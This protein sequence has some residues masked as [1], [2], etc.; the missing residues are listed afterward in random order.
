MGKT[1]T[2]AEQ[3]Q[4]FG[5]QQIRRAMRKAWKRDQ[6]RQQRADAKI[7]LAE[8]RAR[9]AAHEKIAGPTVTQGPG[10][11]TMIGRPYKKKHHEF[12]RSIIRDKD[13]VVPAVTA[14]VGR[15]TIVVVP[16][17]RYEQSFHAT[18]GPRSQRVPV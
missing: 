1:D 6:A 17:R 5:R 4:R 9:R 3:P 15:K 12:R 8:M 14:K 2:I 13:V 11:L 7:D 10:K 18:K 16:E